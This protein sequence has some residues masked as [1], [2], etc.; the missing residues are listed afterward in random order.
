MTKIF[1]TEM[2]NSCRITLSL[3]LNILESEIGGDWKDLA[4]V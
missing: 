4:D 3:P 1:V 2:L